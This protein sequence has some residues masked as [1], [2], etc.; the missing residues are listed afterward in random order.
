[1]PYVTLNS[2]GIGQSTPPRVSGW[3]GLD[4]ESGVMFSTKQIVLGVPHFIMSENNPNP[5]SKHLGPMNRP[6]ARLPKP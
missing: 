2:L 4:L 3:R 6:I 1:M 5:C